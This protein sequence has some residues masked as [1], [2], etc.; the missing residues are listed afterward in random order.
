MIKVG[1]VGFGFMGRTHMKAWQKD[2]LCTVTAVCDKSFE[3]GA[4]LKDVDG[5]IEQDGDLDLTGIQTFSD[6]DAMLAE[7]DVDVISIALPTFLHAD[8]TVKALEAG[9]HVLCEKPMALSLD[10]CDKMV[11]AAERTGN[12]LQVGH[13]IRFWPEYMKAKEIVDSGEYGK[14][15]FANFVR[16]GAK[17]GW[18]EDGWF[19]DDSRSGGMIVDLHI[20]DTDYVL[21]L[22]GMPKSVTCTA[23]DVNGINDHVSAQ[24]EY[25]NGTCVTAEGSWAMAPSFGFRMGFMIGMENATIE[26]N[27]SIEGGLKVYPKDGDAFSADVPEGSGYENQVSHFA[28]LINGDSAPELLTPKHSRDTI[29]VALAE[30]ESVKAKKRITITQ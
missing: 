10:D 9:K 2:S 20:H 22:F 15:L 8:F 27:T 1:I 5:N 29:Q 12:L 16:L 21:H 23:S 24:Y 26:F 7:G 28:K 17:P 18:A 11:D 13:C 14:V 3:G 6:F 19:N 30:R 4:V 25:D